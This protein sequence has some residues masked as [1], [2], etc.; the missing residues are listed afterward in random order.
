MF[1]SNDNQQKNILLYNVGSRYFFLFTST[2]SK[3]IGIRAVSLMTKTF[4]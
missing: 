1:L 4:V 3:F 2:F